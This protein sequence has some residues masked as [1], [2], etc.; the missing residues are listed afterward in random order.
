MGTAPPRPAASVAMA[1]ASSAAHIVDMASG[2]A[3]LLPKI[4]SPACL[5]VMLSGAACRVRHALTSCFKLKFTGINT[6]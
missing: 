1:M 6:A 5:A 4:C 2:A 3:N